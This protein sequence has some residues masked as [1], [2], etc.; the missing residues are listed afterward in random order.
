MCISRGKDYSIHVA[1]LAKVGGKGIG[2]RK[3]KGKREVRVGCR[4][5]GNHISPIYSPNTPRDV[6]PQQVLSIVF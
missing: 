1:A 4:P 2:E 3:R 5:Q 6:L